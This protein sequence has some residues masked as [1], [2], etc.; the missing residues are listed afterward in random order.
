[1]SQDSLLNDVKICN[2]CGAHFS[3]SQVREDYEKQFDGDVD[4][5]TQYPENNLCFNCA[6]EETEAFLQAGMEWESE[7]RLQLARNI[8]R[9]LGLCTL[10]AKEG[11]AM[12]YDTDK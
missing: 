9:D 3:I 6:I 7:R 4:Y 8:C 12:E 5:D 1:M 2:V 11:Y 10:C